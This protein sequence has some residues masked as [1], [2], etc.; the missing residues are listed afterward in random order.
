[1]VA[2]ANPGTVLNVGS[3]VDLVKAAL[4]Y[5]DKVTVISP[6]TTMLLRAEGL[7][8]FNPRQLVDLLR[9]VVPVLLPPG[10]L[11]EFEQGLPEIDRLLR[12]GLRG[13]ISEVNR[14]ALHQL[15]GPGQRM[16]SE[17]VR[18]M[19]A[20]AG[21]D[22]L[23]R[24]RREGYVTIES[25]D[26][27]DEVDLLASCIVSAHL[28]QTGQRQA[29]PHTG[30][31][32]ETFVDKLRKHLSSGK[33]YLIFDEPIASL[34]EAAIRE[35][36]F[37][38]AKGPKGRCAQAMAA[39]GLMGTLPTFP[40]ATVD[41]VIDIR[42]EL[43]PS[44]AQFRSAMV[45]ISKNFAS[46]PWESDFEDELH[47]VWVE[48]V[49]PAVE[50][51]EASVRDNRSLFSLTTDYVGAANTAWSGLTIVAAGLLGHAGAAQ[52]LGGAWAGAAPLLQV[53]RDRRT[54]RNDIRMQPFY[55]LYKAEQALQ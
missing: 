15:L 27:G 45:T 19:N 11:S 17:A 42:R 40:K 46:A 49:H 20:E 7:Q 26:P 3:E 6:V 35:G 12:P 25:A 53:I 33:E 44:L 30:R 18:N 1:M 34:T 24:A 8:Q 28:F 29:N 37:T 55:F 48:T 32:V 38:P 13:G 2:A 41:E 22:Q 10:Q 52:A 9:R 5:G 21:I 16:M 50:A 23:A 51:I 36:L 4:L 47:D 43:A 14:A 54:A 39:S 31:V